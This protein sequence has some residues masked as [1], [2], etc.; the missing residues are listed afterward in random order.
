MLLH[1]T[2]WELMLAT[3]G[4]GEEGTPISASVQSPTTPPTVGADSSNW[5]LRL[6]PPPGG[7]SQIGEI[8]LS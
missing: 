2:E 7:E 8:R 6:L 1:Q 4:T 3:A 5:N